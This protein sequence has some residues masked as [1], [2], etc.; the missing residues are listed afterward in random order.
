MLLY[1]D[2]SQ[3]KVRN[4]AMLHML[5]GTPGRLTEISKISLEGVDRAAANSGCPSATL[6]SPCLWI[7]FWKGK[8]YSRTPMRCGNRTGEGDAAQR[9]IPRY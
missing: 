1:G 9:D 7:I 3:R 8:S 6:A 2:T 5:W 4:R